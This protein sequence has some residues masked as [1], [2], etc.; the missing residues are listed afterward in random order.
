M[1]NEKH[2][3]T[4]AE[5]GERAW[6]RR[7]RRWFAAEGRALAVP[8][9]DDAAGIDIAGERGPL[10]VTTDALI[11]GVHFNFEWTGAKALGA[12]A[13]AVN[14]SDLAAMAARPVGAFLALS[15]PPQTPVRMLEDFFMGLRAEGRRHGCP[16]AG[17][18]MTRAPQ[19][20]ITVTVLG[21]PLVE[22]KVALRSAARPGMDLYVTGA[23][24]ESGAGLAALRAGVKAEK[25]IKRHLTPTPRLNEAAVL[26][27]ACPELAMLD[28]SD[29]IWNDAGQMAEASR[30]RIELERGRVGKLVSPALKRLGER[31]EKDPLEWVLFGGEDYELLFATRREEE[32]LRDEFKKAG[33][34]TK[35]TKIG[36]IAKGQGVSLMDEVGNEINVNDNTFRH[37]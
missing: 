8:I 23:P 26:A 14:L 15:V 18:D 33:L 32:E 25:L 7:V 20:A 13:L 21:L 2:D 34:A 3:K 36:R 4:L 19:W 31:L 30:V 35:V 22:K 29:G 10:L 37:F 5:V 12:K 28:V 6:L 24:G 1:V 9:G 16:L 17:G 27:K 11:E